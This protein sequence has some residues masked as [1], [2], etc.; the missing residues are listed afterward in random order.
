MILTFPESVPSTLFAC[1]HTGTE[2]KNMMT[3]IRTSSGVSSISMFT[4]NNYLSW[5][6]LGAS[7]PQGV[8]H[9]TMTNAGGS[10]PTMTINGESFSVPS[11]KTGFQ[12]VVTYFGNQG[13]TAASVQRG[14][15][16][17]YHARLYNRVL[18]SAELDADYAIDQARFNLT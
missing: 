18:S 3:A 13:A 5:V 6:P 2:N 14:V 16:K 4:T 9:I 8:Q 10:S 1:A 15:P 17:Y 11:S 7:F 12:A